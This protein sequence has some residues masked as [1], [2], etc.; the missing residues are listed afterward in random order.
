[1]AYTFSKGIYMNYPYPQKGKF[2]IYSKSGCLNCVKVKTILKDTNLLF[3]V[4]D[5]D[6]FLLD[7]KQD[8][9]DF[10]KKLIGKEYKIFPMVFDE[11]KFIGGYNETNKY[12]EHFLDFNT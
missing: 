12:L 9:L 2:T 11:N 1:M 10:I 4:I 5:C 7:N 6:E 3:S 8:F